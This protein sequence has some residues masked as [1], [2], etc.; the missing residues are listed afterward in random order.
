MSD[1][2]DVIENHDMP[3]FHKWLADED[4]HRRIDCSVL[5]RAAQYNN[6]EA[7]KALI[8]A[9]V[10]GVSEGGWTPLHT[11]V[12]NN[13]IDICR[14]LIKAGA[15]INALYESMGDD[16][17]EVEAE[18]SACRP[19][20]LAIFQKHNEIASLLI[21]MGADPNCDLYIGPIP[22]F[23]DKIFHNC[24][25][26]VAMSRND[27][28]LA[29]L[30]KAGASLDSSNREG[31]TPL[32]A[33]ITERDINGVTYLLERGANP[34]AECDMDGERSSPLVLAIELYITE[35][36]QP[37][38]LEIIRLLFAKGGLT[39]MYYYK[40]E[41]LI[42]RVLE[43]DDEDLLKLFGLESISDTLEIQEHYLEGVKRL[44]QSSGPAAQTLLPRRHPKFQS[45][46]ATDVQ[47]V[48]QLAEPFAG[49]GEIARELDCT[50]DELDAWALDKEP[51]PYPMWFMLVKI[52]FGQRVDE[53]SVFG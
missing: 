33:M 37:N 9:G 13:N 14:E 11:A 43:S 36:G 21:A 44:Q 53:L 22:F 39:S 38:L 6:V 27:K 45:P 16:C 1:I 51:I 52:A 19:L 25:Q 23:R 49:A 3:T 32:A 35:G 48:L 41:T 15:N 7:C 34:A 12:F 31:Q 8:A 4:R 50:R 17:M 26:M 42:N 28:I 5:H 18:D 46:Q 20:S 2:Y 40:D 30:L 10:D 47:A 29:Q 24:V